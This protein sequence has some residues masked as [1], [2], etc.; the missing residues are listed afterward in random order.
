MKRI[1]T[2][3]PRTVL[4]GR[5]LTSV[6][7]TR[8][9]HSEKKLDIR[10]EGILAV[11]SIVF[12]VLAAISYEKSYSNHRTHDN[13]KINSQ[14]RLQFAMFG[15]SILCSLIVLSQL[16]NKL[17]KHV[18]KRSLVISVLELVLINL[19]AFPYA[20]AEIHI[21]Q[22]SRTTISGNDVTDWLCY[23]ISELLYI[24]CLLKIYFIIKFLVL[25]IEFARQPAHHR[26]DSVHTHEVSILNHLLLAF[27]LSTTCILLLLAEY[28]RVSE[29]PYI[30]ISQKNFDSYFN[31]LW[32]LLVSM[33]SVGYGDF[34]PT[35]YIGRIVC[36]VSAGFGAMIFGIVIYGFTS[37]LMIS[38]RELRAMEKID[39]N[40]ACAGVIKEA[41][42]WNHFKIKYGHG[43]AIE[44]Q[45]KIVMV[46]RL[47]KT[48]LDRK[49][50]EKLKKD[51]ESKI[52]MRRMKRIEEK[53][54]LKSKLI[55]N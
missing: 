30:D 11:L 35:T 13:C 23:K 16:Y 49:I 3:L 26:Y 54:D 22:I 55:I 44:K 51:K 18:P 34:Y 4:R 14:S 36:F 48:N 15:L 6:Q 7:L 25:Y 19:Y 42:L 29:R 8:F 24:F 12:I 50:R 37:F 41:L 46:R 45:Q 33:T 32:C 39:L 40:R 27:I 2:T 38:N 20:E 17:Q 28:L 21:K 43:S 1:I 52:L 47:D 9:I 31:A 10:T 5:H 53:L